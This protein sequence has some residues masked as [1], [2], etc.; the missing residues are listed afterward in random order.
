[1]GQMS[2]CFQFL[3][4]SRTEV[5]SHFTLEGPRSGGGLADGVESSSRFPVFRRGIG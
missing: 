1:M 4:I 3:R 2:S 5:P